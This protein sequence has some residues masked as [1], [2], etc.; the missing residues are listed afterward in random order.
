MSSFNTLIAEAKC[1]VCKN[2]V[3]FEVQFKY[4][5][6]RQHVYHLGDSLIWGANDRGDKNAYRVMVEGIGGPCPC[7][8]TE[9]IDFDILI[10]DNK[11]V[12]LYPLGPSRPSSSP[13]GYVVLDA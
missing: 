11:I 7:C 10:K 6:T 8:H 13:E 3:T 12:E 2:V 1:P 5:S 4:G 9:Y